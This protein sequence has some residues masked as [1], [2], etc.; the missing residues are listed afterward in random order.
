MAGAG[1]LAACGSMFGQPKGPTCPTVNILPDASRVTVYRT[2]PGR[3]LSDVAY[4]AR[5][6]GFDGDCLYKAANKDKEKDGK[7]TEVTLNV[8]PRFRVVPGP[9]LT[10]SRVALNYFVAMPEFYPNPEG[11]ADF[12]RDADVPANRT[13]FE[14]VD[15][16]IQVNIPLGEARAG[17]SVPVYIGFILTEE[18]LQQNRRGTGG[19]LEP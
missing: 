16:D 19:R 17:E 11:R 18:Q 4:E 2:G 3:D 7:F 13:P 15:S 6:I 5:V 1:F 12:S 14:L 9:A 8:R 10:G